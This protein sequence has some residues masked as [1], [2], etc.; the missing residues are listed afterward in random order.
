MA[1]DPRL[2]RS[3]LPL[4]TGL[5]CPKVSRWTKIKVSKVAGLVVQKSPE[6]VAVKGVSNE[7]GWMERG[8]S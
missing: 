4:G 1:T 8:I 2:G 7:T 3:P 6:K 5:H